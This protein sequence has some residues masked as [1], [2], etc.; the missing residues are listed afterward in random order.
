MIEQDLLPPDATALERALSRASA[1]CLRGIRADLEQLTHAADC[2]DELLPW[3]AWS[4]SVASWH[5][6]WPDRIQR[7]SVQDAID[8]HKHRGTVKGVKDAVTRVLALT[9]NPDRDHLRET[10][11]RNV[12]WRRPRAAG[13]AVNNARAEPS[14]KHTFVIR[15]WWEPSDDGRKRDPLTFEVELLVGPRHLEGGVLSRELYETLRRAIDAVKP[16][17]SR[18]RLTVGGEAMRTVIPLATAVRVVQLVRFR[19]V[20]PRVTD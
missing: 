18:Y 19:A 5:D 16:L 2:P 17:T 11:P 20:I 6:D 15:E 12:R 10:Y 3:L 1:T 14:P 7:D 4:L 8:C 13:R 9:V